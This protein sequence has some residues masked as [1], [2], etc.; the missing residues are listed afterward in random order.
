MSNGGRLGRN[1]IISVGGRFTDKTTQKE[2]AFIW[3]DLTNGVA[4]IKDIGIM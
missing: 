4:K 2:L 3:F 1:P